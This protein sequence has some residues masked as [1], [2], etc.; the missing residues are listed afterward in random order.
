M[1]EDEG[2]LTGHLG[3]DHR[4]IRVG[5]T[6]LSIF[7]VIDLFVSGQ[8]QGNGIASSMLARVTE[9]AEQN[10]VDF[11]LLYAID[12]RLYIKNGFRVISPYLK[13][14]WICDFENH[15]VGIERLDNLIYIKSASDKAWPDGTVD[16]M[17]YL[18]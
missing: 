7:G 11:L 14:L 16:I 4:V 17:G 9:I 15:G 5:D 10:R 8:H 18:F 13:S 3:V 12:E 6:T 1:V 2:S